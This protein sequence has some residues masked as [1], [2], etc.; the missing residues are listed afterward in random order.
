MKEHKS[1]RQDCGTLGCKEPALPFSKP[2]R[3]SSHMEDLE[4]W[5]ESLPTAFEEHGLES[6]NHL[7]A[8]ALASYLYEVA[9]LQ[10]PIRG[11]LYRE[12]KNEIDPRETVKFRFADV[13]YFVIASATSGIIGNLAYAAVKSLV[14]RIAGAN[15]EKVIKQFEQVI[16]EVRYEQLR[17]ESHGQEPPLVEV[18][19]D[20]VSEIRTKYRILLER[21]RPKDS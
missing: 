10:N 19:E 3:C 18:H 6:L 11:T 4:S 14:K 17:I 8:Q 13:V 2:P 9:L 20:T 16:S 5:Y 1:L 12:F 15:Q 21:D 7:V